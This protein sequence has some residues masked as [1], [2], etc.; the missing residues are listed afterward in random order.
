MSEREV[1]DS[2]LTALHEAAL[3]DALWPATSALLDDACGMTGNALIV[4]EGTAENA[5]VLFA[6]SY[7]RGERNLDLERFYFSNYYHVDERIPRIRDLPDA[8]PTHV[9]ALYS[10]REKRT[11]PAYNEGLPHLGSQ[12][13]IDVRLDGPDGTRIIWAIADPSRGGDWDSARVA[14]IE[15]LLPHI[16]QYVRTRYALRGAEA[17]NASLLGLLNDTG[18]G[19]VLLDRGGRIIEANDPALA[20]LTGPPGL[21]ETDG[22]LTAWLPSDDRNLQKLLARALPQPGVTSQAAG[23]MA[24]SRTSGM[25]KLVLQITPVKGHVPDF[26]TRRVAALVLLRDPYGRPRLDAGLTG[27]ALGLTPAESQVA[28]GLTEGRTL[29]EV[30]SATGRTKGTVEVLLKRAYRKLGVSRQAELVRLVL[31]AG[32]GPFG[33]AE[34]LPG[35]ERRELTQGDPLAE[36]PALLPAASRERGAEPR[37]TP[38]ERERPEPGKGDS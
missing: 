14:M 23:A 38:P 32:P 22:F 25:A 33:D 34:T 18:L 8:L 19:I 4:G 11:S 29:V 13:G 17:R 3:D 15:R 9:P 10:E 24:V 31:G 2:L 20:L 5:R 28:V 12:N 26:G 6:E 36:E 1:F 7:R 21:S 16:R 35:V 30:A 27:E 37:R